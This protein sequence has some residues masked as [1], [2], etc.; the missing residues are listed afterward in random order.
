MQQRRE[1]SPENLENA[2]P[3]FEANDGKSWTEANSNEKKCEPEPS[4]I[5]L[6]E[7]KICKLKFP[8]NLK[9]AKIWPQSYERFTSL[10]SQACE[11]KC[12]L[13]S[14]VVT[15]MVEFNQLMLII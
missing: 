15:S 7:V 3:G 1:I 10:Y 6:F 14:F 12:F 8:K 11:Y 9:V 13:K 2:A 4:V 5:K